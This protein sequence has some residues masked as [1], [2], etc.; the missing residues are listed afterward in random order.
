MSGM[1]SSATGRS[2]EGNT[3]AFSA[4]VMLRR[5]VLIEQGWLVDGQA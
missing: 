4:I 2:E 1:C 3:V 5:L